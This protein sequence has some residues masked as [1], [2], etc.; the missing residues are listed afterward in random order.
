[1]VVFHSQ[2]WMTTLVPGDPNPAQRSLTSLVVLEDVVV[3]VTA[4]RLFALAVTT[5]AVLRKEVWPSRMGSS[6]VPSSH[7]RLAP[8]VHSCAR[9]AWLSQV[10][11]H[12][13]GGQRRGVLQLAVWLCV[14]RVRCGTHA[15][16]LGCFLWT[17]CTSRALGHVNAQV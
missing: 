12:G 11:G 10:C 9:A 16:T 14:C 6:Y 5:G 1:M 2:L 15:R 3:A 4:S 17:C 13:G 7:P 8:F